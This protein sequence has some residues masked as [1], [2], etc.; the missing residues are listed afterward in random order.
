MQYKPP[1][2]VKDL[3]LVGGGHSH[4]AVLKRFGMKP[5]PGIRLTLVCRDVHTPYSGMLPGLISGHYEYD[6][7]HIDLVKLAVFASARFIHDEVIGMDLYQKQLKFQKRPPISYDL[8]SLNIGSIP[9]MHSVPGAAE[10][11]VA[12][13]PIS[14]FLPRWEALLDRIKQLKETPHIAVVGAG[15]GGVELALSI[16]HR[17]HQYF[18]ALGRSKD[19]EMHLFTSERQI[20]T[21]HNAWVR[22][23]FERILGE[24]TITVHLSS[25]VISVAANGFLSS[26]G[27]CEKF[28]EIVWVTHASATSW[29]AESGI[30][31]DKQGFVVVDKY[32]RSLSHPEIFAAGD[33]ATMESSPREKAGVFAVRQG[34]PLANNLQRILLGKNPKP[35][36]PQSKFLSLVS[37]GDKYAVASRSSWSVEGRWVWKLKDWIDRRFMS[38]YEDLPEMEGPTNEL[39]D[40][41]SSQLLDL[42]R[43]AFE[44]RCRGCASKLGPVT[45]QGAL[46]N[47][48]SVIR[49]DV[50]VGLQS[51][52]D[53]AV[54]EV[55]AGKVLVQSVDF[56]P[57]IV[58]DPYL[59]GQIAANHA[60]GDI[61][62][63]GATPQ[64]ALA[65]AGIPFGTQGKTQELL[66]QLLLGANEVFQKTSTS[67]AG[68]HSS[69]CP[70]MALGFVINGLADEDA[71]LR[72]DRLQDGDALILTKPL[73][74]GVLFA[75][76]MRLKSKGRWIKSAIET[77]LQSSQEAVEIL[78][79]HGATACTDVTGF[80]LAGHLIEMLQF[81]RLAAE[82]E[83]DSIPVLTG[84]LQCFE[85]GITSSLHHENLK[86]WDSTGS[87]PRSAKHPAFP[88]LFDPQTAGGLLTGIPESN[89]EECIKALQASGY[90]GAKRIGRICKQDSAESLLKLVSV[91]SLKHPT[92]WIT[93]N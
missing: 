32:L 85:A 45:L 8:L 72:K 75:S 12:V 25:P 63:M 6:D 49:E 37:T 89:A 42:N 73:G 67:L 86:A 24:R 93:R 10:F 87:D 60:L 77:M 30:Q 79:Q 92:N 5:I 34:P 16:Q 46:N 31:T 59:F 36:R 41:L 40:A 39:P 23:K 90:S 7:A 54:M 69:E 65:V 9:S 80:G 56:F 51:R 29:L 50:L 70:E 48:K 22:K 74:T 78:R 83:L 47:F 62:A 52:D 76:E 66:Q 17:L 38:K 33:I 84:S 61:F 71:V 58:D 21:T 13:K 14:N 27:F 43:S 18:Q 57:A 2:I 3:V 1:P 81:S 11:A 55:P 28:H 64:S 91:D 82:V 53:A 68:G 35:Y 26:E 20:L 88:L 15:A 4:I 44:M 19:L